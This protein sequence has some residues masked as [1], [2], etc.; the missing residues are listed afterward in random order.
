MG[1]SDLKHD[2]QR[3]LEWAD[4][5]VNCAETEARPALTVLALVLKDQVDDRSEEA[6]DSTAD[7]CSRYLLVLT[8]H[9][10]DRRLGRRQNAEPT[11]A[12][13]GWRRDPRVPQQNTLRCRD[14]LHPDPALS[15]THAEP[16]VQRQAVGGGHLAATP[17]RQRRATATSEERAGVSAHRRRSARNLAWLASVDDAPSWTF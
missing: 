14:E 1:W 10:P 13:S 7:R 4:V 5:S 16:H 9:G 8:V 6:A 11:D 15:G 17:E 12:T 2:L 3:F